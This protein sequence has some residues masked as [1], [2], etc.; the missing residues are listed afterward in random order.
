MSLHSDLLDT[1][2]AE[3][4]ALLANTPKPLEA[5]DVA[6]LD[7]YL[8]GVLIQPR[9]IDEAEWLPGIFDFDD[10]ALP[11][12][13]DPAWLDRIT[14]LTRRRHTALQR[15]LGEHGWFDPVVV[16]Q[17][18]GDTSEA[19]ETT[20]ASD[21]PLSEAEQLQHDTY[22]ALAPASR[23]LLAWVSGF[24]HALE[25]FPELAEFDDPAIDTALAR[26]FRHL[27]AETDEEKE[28]LATLDREHPLKDVD[29]AVEELVA[30]VADLNDLTQS[31]RYH[32]DPIRRDQP[33]VG[34]NDPCPCGS[35]RKYKA[36]HGK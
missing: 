9:L 23:P 13:A 7:G 24:A 29:D 33:K 30:C 26:L 19:A 15:S 5:L 32:V 20:E 35:G 1:E 18:D 22:A 25:R 12:D 31:A 4:D 3:L 11:A 17:P 8:C 14:T 10:R 16:D 21:A 34:R 28:I 27:P 6:M 36:C 2:F